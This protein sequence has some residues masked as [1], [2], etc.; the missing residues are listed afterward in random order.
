LHNSAS[1][2]ISGFSGS[3]G[4]ALSVTL[5]KAS[6]SP[7]HRQILQLFKGLYVEPRKPL[8]EKAKTPY[9]WH[10]LAEFENSLILYQG[11]VLCHFSLFLPKFSRKS[12]LFMNLKQG[13]SIS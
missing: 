4:I 5:C 6:A 8:R 13:L 2:P 3:R 12:F 10:I 1:L 9:F 7:E 11:C